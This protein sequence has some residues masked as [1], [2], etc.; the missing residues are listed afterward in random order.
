MPLQARAPA[1]RH[2]RPRGAG[3]CATTTAMTSRAAGSPASVTQEV[4]APRARH[5]L[6]KDE[7]APTEVR[8]EF[9]QPIALVALEH[10]G[11]ALRTARFR[12]QGPS[13]GTRRPA[14]GERLQPPRTLAH[15]TRV[16]RSRRSEVADGLD[17]G[18]G[19]RVGAHGPWKSERWHHGT[20]GRHLL[21]VRRQGPELRLGACLPDPPPLRHMSLHHLLRRV[22]DRRVPALARSHSCPRSRPH[23]LMWARRKRALHRAGGALDTG[24]RGCPLAPASAV[25]PST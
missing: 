22:P 15:L 9:H 13:A 16:R 25:E 14:V 19:R 23:P 17:H 24:V 3:A 8:S 4:S 11:A 18:R 21:Q 12:H 5:E 7:D 1:A 20:P 2:G 6:A 10:E